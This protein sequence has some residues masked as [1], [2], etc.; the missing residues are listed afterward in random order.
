MKRALSILLLV[1]L[2]IPT[3]NV[4]FFSEGTVKVPQNSRVSTSNSVE[5][6][7]RQA[8]SESLAG[9]L[10]FSEARSMTKARS[11][12]MLGKIAD[13]GSQAA[14]EGAFLALGAFVFMAV[15]SFATWLKGVCF[16]G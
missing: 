2:L 12:G 15:L 4:A 16:K 13:K 1:T 10:Y 6:S 3:G 5:V 7:A 8:S 9:D 14:V 11:G